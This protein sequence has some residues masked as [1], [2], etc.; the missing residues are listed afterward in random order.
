MALFGPPSV[1]G[2]ASLSGL[3]GREERWIPVAE[4]VLGELDFSILKR[5]ILGEGRKTCSLGFAKTKKLKTFV[6][7][8]PFDHVARKLVWRRLV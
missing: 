6:S 7:D 5:L 4:R 8:R 1:S 2:F 3:S